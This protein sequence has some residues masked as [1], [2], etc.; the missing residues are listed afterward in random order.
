VAVALAAGVEVVAVPVLFYP[1]SKTVWA[2]I[3]VAMHRGEAWAGYHAS[4]GGADAGPKP[5]QSGGP[6]RG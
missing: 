5:K 4:T 6:S 3:D 1:F 2:A